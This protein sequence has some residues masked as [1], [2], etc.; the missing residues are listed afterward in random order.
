ML[1]LQLSRAR[2]RHEK[3]VPDAAVA[4][5]TIVAASLDRAADRAQP[6]RPTSFGCRST[7]AQ[8][9]FQL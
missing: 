9:Q 2:M 3:T 6:F 7:Q 5:A 8:P 1:R 4:Y